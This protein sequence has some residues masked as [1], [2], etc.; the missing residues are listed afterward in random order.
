MS[1]VK[2]KEDQLK[3]PYPTQ[4]FFC[5]KKVRIPFV[6][7]MGAGSGESVVVKGQTFEPAEDIS[8]HPNCVG[9]LFVRLLRDL[10]EIQGGPNG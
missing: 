1:V 6:H 7:W 10:K 2:S 4:C 9:Q 8:L 5:G 3:Y